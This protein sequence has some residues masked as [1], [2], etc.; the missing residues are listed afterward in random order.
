MTLTFHKKMSFLKIF[1]S[2]SQV[3]LMN[4]LLVTLELLINTFK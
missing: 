3:V 4:A 1:P 2:I